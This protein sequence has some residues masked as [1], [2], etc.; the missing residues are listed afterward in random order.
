METTKGQHGSVSLAAL[1]QA[2]ESANARALSEGTIVDLIREE[3]IT[4][5]TGRGASPVIQL[6]PIDFVR[7]NSLRTPIHDLDQDGGDGPQGYSDPPPV[8]VQFESSEHVIIVEGCKLQFPDGS[9]DAEFTYLMLPNGLQLSYGQIVALGGDFYGDPAHPICRASGPAAQQAQF[10]ANYRSIAESA[11]APAEVGSIL[12]ILRAEFAAV[13]R[14]IANGEQP[15]AAYGHLGDELSRKWNDATQGRYLALA[16]TNFDHFGQDALTAYLAGHT[17]AARMAAAAH[18]EPDPATRSLLLGQAYAA[19]AFADHFLTDLFSAGHRRTPRWRMWED[20][21]SGSI[22][23]PG[24]GWFSAQDLASLLARG[25][26][27]EENRF[28]VWATNERGDRWVTYGDKRFRDKANYP[29]LLMVRKACQAS[30]DDIWAAFEQGRVPT[31]FSVLAYVS[32]LEVDANDRNN[33]SPLFRLNNG[34]VERRNDVE[35]RSD[36]TWKDDWWLLSTAI[37]MYK[38]GLITVGWVPPNPGATGEIGFP[39]KGPSGA[40][41]RDLA[42]LPPYGQWPTAGTGGPTGQRP[43]HV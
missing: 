25:M 41:G 14:A 15:S 18:S 4:I 26:H 30:M 40:T 7:Q 9:R 42:Y 22:Y 36:Y 24:E 20:E 3:G 21:P 16:K 6:R 32:K 34:K 23:W 27:D 11:S 17:V 28:G 29:N 43:R 5:H 38:A 10:L 8:H 35:S 13:A 39:P 19:N 31:S 1:A 2:H 33:W 12:A 37:L